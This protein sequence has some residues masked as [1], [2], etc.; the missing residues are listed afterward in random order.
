LYPAGPAARKVGESIDC[1]CNMEIPVLHTQAA[2]FVGPLYGIAG[3]YAREHSHI[4]HWR[5][6]DF[7]TLVK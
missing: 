2:D 4:K 5:S 6:K 7:A 1:Q 3:A